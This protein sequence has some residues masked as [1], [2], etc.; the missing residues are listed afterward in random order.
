MYN[1]VRYS[2]VQHDALGNGYLALHGLHESVS[3]VF[4]LFS[5]FFAFSSRLSPL[6]PCETLING[7][8]W[9]VLIPR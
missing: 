1:T 2:I 7:M 5:F 3:P 8:W 4:L 9:L 6:G